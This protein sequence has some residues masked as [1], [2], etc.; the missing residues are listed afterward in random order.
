MQDA[1]LVGGREA[2]PQQTREAPAPGVYLHAGRFPQARWAVQ[3]ERGRGAE[4]GRAGRGQ[5]HGLARDS[6]TRSPAG[7]GATWRHGF[8]LP[9]FPS[10]FG[11]GEVSGPGP[12]GVGR[13]PCGAK[14]DCWATGRLKHAGWPCLAGGSA[15]SENARF[16]STSWK[17]VPE[18]TSGFGFLFLLMGA[19][20]A[21]K[22]HLYVLC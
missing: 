19:L 10:G 5:A 2:G 4:Q 6:E 8:V 15:E 14:V 22:Q 11:L 16:P 12:A 17:G 3:E 7:G 13:Q 20:A 21:C 9:F 1:G 18:A